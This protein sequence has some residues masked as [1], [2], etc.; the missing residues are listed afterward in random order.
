MGRN[1]IGLRALWEDVNVDVDMHG[2]V[3]CEQRE[4]GHVKTESEIGGLLPQAKERLGYQQLEEV[5]RDPCLEAFGGARLGQHLVLGLPPSRAAGQYISVVSSHPVWSTLFQQPW[6]TT[7]VL[8]FP[9]YFLTP[10]LQGTYCVPGSVL[11]SGNWT[12]GF[13]LIQNRSKTPSRRMNFHTHSVVSPALPGIA[14]PSSPPGLLL[15]TAALE[16]D[17]A[18]TGS[19]LGD[20]LRRDAPSG[21]AALDSNMSSRP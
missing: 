20:L 4:D 12:Q 16:A 8:S 17:S 6:N 18:G 10:M 2:R 7:Q 5:R 19:D 11:N 14:H 15:A 9:L 13:R 21:K 3:A 1:P